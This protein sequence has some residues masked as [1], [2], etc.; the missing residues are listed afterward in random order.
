M[1]KYLL[2]LVT[3]ALVMSSC[4]EQFVGENPSEMMSVIAKKEYDVLMEQARWG[5]GSAFL[6]LADCYRDGYG[7]KQDF[8]GML[9][10]LVLAEEFERVIL[11]ALFVY[12][13]PKSS[14]KFCSILPF[15]HIRYL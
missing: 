13:M 11:G 14:N 9:S 10:M 6:Q 15:D 4:T 1:K 3:V 2:A 7:V 12:A 8:V 5:D